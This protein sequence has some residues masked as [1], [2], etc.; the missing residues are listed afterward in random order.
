[1][2]REEPFS[3]ETLADLYAQQGL[4]EKAT[5]IYRQILDQTPANETVKLKLD[6]LEAPALHDTETLQE[7]QRPEEAQPESL[8][9]NDNE[10][11]LSVLE[12]LLENVERI[13]KP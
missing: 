6:A 13:K 11:T 4:V 5:N 8:Q 2:A 10:D 9:L 3:T 12:G 7:V 1:V